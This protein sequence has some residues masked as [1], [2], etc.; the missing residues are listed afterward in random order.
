[1]KSVSVIVRSTDRICLK[2]AIES[3]SKQTYKNVEMIIVDATGLGKINGK[4]FGTN[5]KIN[6]VCEDKPLNRP[7]AANAGL[8]AASGEEIIFLDDDDLF[9]GIHIEKLITARKNNPENL[10]AYTDVEVLGKGSERLLV[11]NY[12]WSKSRLLLANFIPINAVL[13]S[14]ELFD[15]GCFFDE[16]LEILEDWDWWLQL[17]ERTEFTHIPNISACYRYGLGESNHAQSYPYWRS[18]LYKKWLNIVGID[19]FIQDSFEWSMQADHDHQE[20]NLLL[21]K[22][23]KQGTR[24]HTLQDKIEQRGSHINKLRDEVALQ[25]CHLDMLSD[26][27]NKRDIHIKTLQDKIA[28]VELERQQILN[29]R[30]WRIT[31]PIRDIRKFTRITKKI[32]TRLNHK[33]ALRAIQLARQ[34]NWGGIYRRI[35]RVAVN[36]LNENLDTGITSIENQ[37][38]KI[39][40]P[41]LSECID[42]SGFQTKKHMPVTIVIPVYNG[43]DYLQNFFDSVYNNTTEPY[44]LVVINDASTDERVASFLQG[45]KERFSYM[46]LLQNDTNQGFVRSV[47]R[48][49]QKATHELSC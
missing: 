17:A 39:F 31:K 21:D 42:I 49:M 32:T 6:I 22:V 4:N 28:S 35:G 40:W 30:S 27:V 38:K 11:Y 19:R 34:G 33:N 25:T 2:D 18:V 43:F 3:I 13:F 29:S 46:S 20:I 5:R 7:Q 15:S 47:N 41:D 1:M 8:R 10:A 23:N 9:Y 24:I 12:D 16:E 26:E 48:G 14:R 37:S 45:Q 44:D 36:S